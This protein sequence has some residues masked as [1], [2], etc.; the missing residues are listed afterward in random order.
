MQKLINSITSSVPT[1]LVE[2]CKLGRALKQRDADVLAFSDRLGT[3]NA[4]TGAINGRLEHLH[5]TV[6][7]F[8]PLT[9]YVARSLLKTSGFA[10]HL[11][12][13]M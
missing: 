11:N 2:L 10:N 4:L 7:G 6:L 12:A 13:Q 5:G 8:R 1:T 9:N 3:G